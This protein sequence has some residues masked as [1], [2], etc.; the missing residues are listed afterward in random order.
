MGCHQDGKIYFSSNCTM[1]ASFMHKIAM[2][3]MS[4]KGAKV[5]ALFMQ[6]VMFTNKTMACMPMEL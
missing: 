2:I 4:Q 6:V 3:P 1:T 5:I